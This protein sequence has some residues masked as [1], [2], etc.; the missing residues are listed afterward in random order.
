MSTAIILLA[1]FIIAIYALKGTI[2]HF[3][4][5]GGCCGGGSV[6]KK[7]KKKLT[8]PVAAAYLVK[9]EGMHCDHCKTSVENA[10]NELEGVTAEVH[11]KQ[12]E[13][14]VQASRRVEASEIEDAVKKAGFSV[15]SVENG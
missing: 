15:S 11:L 9:I 8:Q 12:G 2:K 5:Q 10:L 13:A 1:L 7:K 3:M 4:G 14:L 6:P